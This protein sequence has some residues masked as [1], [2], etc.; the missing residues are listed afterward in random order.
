MKIRT[1]NFED[2]VK[3][4]RNKNDSYKLVEVTR[5]AQILAYECDDIIDGIRLL[6]AECTE[7]KQGLFVVLN[8]LIQQLIDELEEFEDYHKELCDSCP[9]QYY[10]DNV[11][12]GADEDSSEA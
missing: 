10:I 11:D 4:V 5:H 6:P 1:R 7:V 12:R 8:D 3:F 9:P 2:L